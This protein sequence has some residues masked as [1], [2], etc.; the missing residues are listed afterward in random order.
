MPEAQRSNNDPGLIIVK[1]YNTC[2]TFPT[3]IASCISKYVNNF[4]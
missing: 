3:R 4:K 1:A 2:V